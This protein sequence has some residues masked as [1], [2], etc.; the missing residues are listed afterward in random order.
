[1]QSNIN[2]HNNTHMFECAI[3]LLQLGTCNPQVKYV[4]T[5]DDLIAWLYQYDRLPRLRRCTS[6]ETRLANLLNGI[7]TK[8]NHRNHARLWKLEKAL[9]RVDDTFTTFAQCWAERDGKERAKK[10]SAREM[11]RGEE[12]EGE[13]ERKRQM[14]VWHHANNQMYFS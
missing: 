1:M 11:D 4:L 5:V 14:F 12:K 9:Q 2:T 7:K 10:R 13:P 6:T 8:K 3:H